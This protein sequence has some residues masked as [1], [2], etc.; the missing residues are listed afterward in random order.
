MLKIN[1]GRSPSWSTESVRRMHRSVGIKL[2]NLT[3]SESHLLVQWQ[4]FLDNFIVETECHHG[5]LKVNIVQLQRITQQKPFSWLALV[6]E[7]EKKDNFRC[8]PQLPTYGSKISSGLT[9]RTMCLALSEKRYM[10]P[11]TARRTVS[12]STLNFSA[13]E[14]RVHTRS[15][16]TVPA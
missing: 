6:T 11:S 10:S 8:F 16:A 12:A 15:V 14:S 2:Q 3:S 1:F 7:K 5:V 13:T 4:Q 9:L